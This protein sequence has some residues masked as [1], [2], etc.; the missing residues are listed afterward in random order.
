[1]SSTCSSRFRIPYASRV[2]V[3][4]FLSVV[5]RHYFDAL[6]LLGLTI[7]TAPF[8]ARP[9]GRALLHCRLCAAGRVPATAGAVGAAAAGPGG[10]RLGRR[11]DSGHTAHAPRGDPVPVEV[12]GRP[13]AVGRPR[14]G[15]H[16]AARFVAVRLR[17]TV[18]PRRGSGGYRRRLGHLG[19]SR[20]ELPLADPCGADAVGGAR[21]RA[22]TGAGR[23]G[24]RKPRRRFDRPDLA[25]RA[26]R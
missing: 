8:S 24:V 19:G 4:A 17:G 22:A 6:L 7:E 14:T 26:G 3:A 23:A 9:A 2:P 21:D 12:S 11:M 10:S 25:V 20:E 16:R 5:D 1:M 18:G 13:E 15:T